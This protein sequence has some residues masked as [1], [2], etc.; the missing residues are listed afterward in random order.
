MNEGAEESRQ[1]AKHLAKCVQS[2]RANV[3]GRG[4]RKVN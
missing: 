1:M 4:K 3:G 2:E